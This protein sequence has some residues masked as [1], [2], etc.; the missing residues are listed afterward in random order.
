M[1]FQF[2]ITPSDMRRFAL[3]HLYHT[4]GIITAVLI[5]IIGIV[6]F[7]LYGYLGEWKRAVLLLILGVGF[8]LVLHLNI[9]IRATMQA[10]NNQAFAAGLT[11][12][13]T[14]EEM[15]ISQGE[16][17]SKVAWNMI[18]KTRKTGHLLLLYTDRI[19]SFLIPLN[20]IESLEGNANEESVDTFVKQHVVT[21]K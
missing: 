19:H 20:R 3:Y 5:P 8:S 13:F 15:I 11:Y 10:A 21:V 7:G 6:G 2:S 12:E 18:I 17:E 14:E 16:Q 4:S 9:L 1:K